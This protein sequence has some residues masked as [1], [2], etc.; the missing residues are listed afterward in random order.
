A[1]TPVRIAAGLSRALGGTPAH[2][3][4]L[5]G[6][7]PDADA[8]GDIVV[9]AWRLDLHTAQRIHDWIEDGAGTHLG[10]LHGLAL[11]RAA[12]RSFRLRW[13]PVELL[14][15]EQRQAH[16]VPAAWR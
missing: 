9:E 6:L 1:H 3:A 14:S 15:E 11:E 16:G 8:S 10:P 13:R 5:A 7:L 2:E 12:D 4:M